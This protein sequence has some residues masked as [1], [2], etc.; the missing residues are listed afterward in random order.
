MDVNGSSECSPLITKSGKTS[1]E[2]P[3]PFSF[4]DGNIPKNNCIN[5]L[6]SNNGLDCEP[7]GTNEPTQIMN[8][9]D[10]LLSDEQYEP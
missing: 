4:N 10:T 6:A 1:F 2:P 5:L 8:K 7:L 9:F 3:P